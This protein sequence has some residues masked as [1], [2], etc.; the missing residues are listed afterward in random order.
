MSNE[1]MF[2]VEQ[3]NSLVKEIN[4]LSLLDLIRDILMRYV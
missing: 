1:K 2:Y 3:I 4:D